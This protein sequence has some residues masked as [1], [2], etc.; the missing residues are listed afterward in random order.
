MAGVMLLLINSININ[1]ER[2]ALTNAKVKNGW[3]GCDR[4]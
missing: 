3:W 1:I 4:K 2:M